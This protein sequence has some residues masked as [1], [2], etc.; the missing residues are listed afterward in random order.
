MTLS[1]P[2][3]ASTA[4]LVASA[5][6]FFA[7]ARQSGSYSDIV[8]A[9]DDPVQTAFNAVVSHIYSSGVLTPASLA[10]R[11][12]SKKLIMK[13]VD[14]LTWTV[15]DEAHS[16]ISPEGQAFVGMMWAARYDWGD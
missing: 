1:R 13:V 7:I 4:L 8:S 15:P 9:L 6:R 12:Y 16:V 14:P 11:R 10:Q 3:T 5:Y 2:D